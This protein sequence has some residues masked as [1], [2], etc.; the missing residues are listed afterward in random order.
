MIAGDTIYA[1]SRVLGCKQQAHGLEV[2][3]RLVG[4]KNLSSRAA[5]ERHGDE[6]FTPERSKQ[7]RKIPEK[8]FEITRTLLVAGRGS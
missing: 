4:V 8:V 5:L 6:L 2:Q 1:A 3:L 7:E